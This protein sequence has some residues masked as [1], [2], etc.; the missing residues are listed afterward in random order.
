MEGQL[1]DMRGREESMTRVEREM[2]QEAEGLEHVSR[3]VCSDK[4]VR[5]CVCVYLC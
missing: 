3:E 2:E 5:V 4:H 1:H